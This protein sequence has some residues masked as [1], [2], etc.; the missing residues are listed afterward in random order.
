[1]KTIQKRLE[2][3]FDFDMDLYLMVYDDPSLLDSLAETKGVGAA[4]VIN[5]IA[6]YLEDPDTQSL[7]FMLFRTLK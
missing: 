2:S 6:Y 5:T 3:T 1:M 4:R 7:K